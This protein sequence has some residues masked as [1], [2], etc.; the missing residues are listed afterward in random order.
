MQRNEE[1]K[2]G[3]IFRLKT[4]LDSRF[5]QK[6]VNEGV[7]EAMHSPSDGEH[8]R[9]TSTATFPQANQHNGDRRM[10]ADHSNHATAT[11]F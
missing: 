8:F 5:H 9:N 6:H 4:K 3:L 10:S 11:L 2:G 7:G 1:S